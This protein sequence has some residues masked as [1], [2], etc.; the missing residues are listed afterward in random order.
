MVTNGLIQDKPR[1]GKG[2]YRGMNP[3]SRANL[4]PGL[5]PNGRP[6]KAVCIT[7]W[8][9]EY[10]DRCIV[11]KV[12]PETLTYAQAAALK[13]WQ[14]AVKGDLSY[15]NFICD[16][17]EGK[18]GERVDVTSKGEAIG[19]GDDIRAF[20][21]GRIASLAARSGTPSDNIQSN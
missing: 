14:Q 10:A 4:R 16:R 7:S 20:I 13:A 11:E 19:N 18:V 17:T 9:K 15:Y 6:P 1:N 21:T 5:N 8:L 3:K 2:N 12:A